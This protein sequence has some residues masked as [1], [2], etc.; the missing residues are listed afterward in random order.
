M[1]YNHQLSYIVTK[2]KKETITEDLYKR[3]Y[4]K[5]ASLFIKQAWDEVLGKTS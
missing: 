2:I 4:I 5:N 3:L 1:L